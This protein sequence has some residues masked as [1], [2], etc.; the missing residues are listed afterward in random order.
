MTEKRED[1]RWFKEMPS[2][3]GGDWGWLLLIIA[4]TVAIWRYTC[5]L[6]L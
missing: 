3:S 1:D 2:P 5:G 6:P 4:I